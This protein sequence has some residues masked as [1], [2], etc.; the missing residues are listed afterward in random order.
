M[1][2]QGRLERVTRR[3]IAGWCADDEVESVL[4]VEVRV[5]ALTLCTVRADMPRKD[6]EEALGRRV[7]GFNFPIHSTLARVLPHGSHIEVASKSGV[8]L[9]P[10]ENIA[11]TID[12]PDGEPD[13]KLKEMLLD[14]Y[15]VNP[16]YGQIFRPVGGRNIDDK[17]F[18]ALA[19][20]N[21]V[22][23]ELLGK[24]FFICYGTLLGCLRENDFIAHDDDVDVCFL[25]DASG[26]EAATE[27]FNAVVATLRE[28]GQRI[29]VDSG[30]QFH[31]GLEG[32]SL[33]V[34]MAWMEGD[35]LYMFN[36]GGEF[37]RSRIEPLVTHDFKGHD[38]LTPRD[39]EALLELIYGPGWRIPD[40]SFQW[41]L[42]PELREKMSQLNALSIVDSRTH[43]EIKQYWSSFY[44]QAHTAV[45]SP[46]AAS[47]AVELNEKHLVVD[48]GCGNGRDSLFF[49]SL[50]HRIHGLDLVDSAI[51]SCR[52]RADQLG[53][54]DVAFE[55]VDVCTPGVLRNVLNAVADRDESASPMIVYARFFF[56]AITEDEEALIIRTLAD[57]LRRRSFCFF[58]FR[59]EKD[60]HTHKRIGGHYRRFIDLD[61]FVA[62]AT[63]GRAFECTYR[64]E[65]Q[66]MA[67]YRD[68]D[69][70]VARVYL[71]RI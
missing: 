32:T 51:E 71:R 33:D 54:D 55:Q 12:N 61:R 44:E 56:H 70:F 4:E 24:Q 22:F 38:V 15:V 25:A 7:A 36:A 47:V 11:T 53:L 18:R 26:L 6:I 9:R 39:S 30:A 50:G 48:L 60:Q 37:P 45:P 19:K 16:K 8:V 27:E 34:F 63:R 10:L 40:P 5:D 46:F 62:K 68:E 31:W 35:R 13:G 2:I 49:A 67:K 14:G 23:T 29:A 41:R 66:G 43:Q 42:T 58:E 20:G 3:A 21:E 57:C 64:V 28:H 17:I 65:G 52:L 69:P 59:T 1:A